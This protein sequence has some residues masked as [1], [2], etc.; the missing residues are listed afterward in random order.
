MT[1]LPILWEEPEEIDHVT[2]YSIEHTVNGEPKETTV[3]FYNTTYY[4]V[5]VEMGDSS[6]C[7]TITAH[8]QND[9]DQVVG[10]GCT[11]T[12]Q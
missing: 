3:V 10:E 9:S 5:A 6:K 7:F 2:S 1:L 12:G 8:K 11:N 4:A